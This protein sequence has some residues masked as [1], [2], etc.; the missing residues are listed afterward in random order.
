MV[1]WNLGAQE[2]FGGVRGRAPRLLA[3]LVPS[4]YDLYVVALQE[5]VSDD[6]FD[7]F[8][9]AFVHPHASLFLLLKLLRQRRF[10]VLQRP[11]F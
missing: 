8:D 9:Q 1:T 10:L 6:L 5:A 4:G 2:P 11:H 7:A 3:P